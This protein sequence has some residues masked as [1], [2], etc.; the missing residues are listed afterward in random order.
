MS[1]LI[2]AE[3]ESIE[4]PVIR[5][6]PP[7][8]RSREILGR[9]E[10]HAYPGLADGLAPFALASKRA[11]TVTDVD[12]NVYLDLASASASV[13]LGAGREE[14]IAPA[15]EAMRR[16]GNEDSHA[17][18]SELT[19]E[20]GERLLA[21]G[22]PGLS[23]YDLALNGTEAVEIAVKMMRRATGRPVV[24]GFLGA[25][26]GEST[27][28]AALGAEHAEI[29]RGLRGL[30]P[31]FVHVPYPHPY[32]SPLRE[33]RPGGSGDATVDYLRD[34]VLF[35]ALDPGEVAGVVIE[36]VLGSGGCV[37]PPDSFWPALVELCA[38][39]GWL[40]CADEVKTGMGRSGHL[41]A[42]ERWAVEP[43]LVCLGKALGGG[44]MPIG[45]VLGS[46]RAMGFDDVPTGSTWSWLPASCAAA[47]ATL[48]FYEREP[49][50]ENVRE[51]ERLAAERLAAL[52]DRFE[53]IGDVRAIGCFEAIEF[54]RDRETKQRATELQH[55]VAAGMCH[56]GVIAD[57]STTSLNLQPSLVMPVAALDR[58][59]AIV[60]E[61]I[62][63]ALAADGG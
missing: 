18:A 48:D 33:P 61:A 2:P 47:L 3:W 12:D 14:L 58:A 30:M 43:D 36:P 52:R 56:R 29:S 17:L 4:A 45:A 53:A 31:G 55:A 59:L 8:P 51:L 23:R 19:A 57:S 25:Y 50:L 15:V 21:I 7:G 34:H 60:A 6:E 10:R 24:I 27:T 11:W 26:H 49:V 22:P 63:A 37:A 46:E 5:T 9:I 54:V 44:V 28:T 42:V 13:P 62:D 41:L 35:H 20:L 16:F 32:R 40:L 38:E 39:H 1:P